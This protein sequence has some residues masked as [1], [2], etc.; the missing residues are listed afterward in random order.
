MWAVL[1]DIH[2][3]LEALEAVLA[4]IAKHPVSRVVC[5]G[6]VV[7]YGPSPIECLERA[8]KWDLVLLGNHD[9]AVL[10]D[11]EGFSANA[12]A[13]ILWTRTVLDWGKRTDLWDYL[14]ERPRSH[15]DGEFLFVH[16]TP[17]DTLNEY[18]FPEDVHN[19][20]KMNQLGSLM[21][22]YCFNGHSH[23]PGVYVEPGGDG[24]GEWK[25]TAPTALRGN[26]YRLD[27]RKTVINVGSVGQPRDG[28]WRASYALV[29]GLDITFR[30]VEYDV[31]ATVKKIHDIPEL[32]DFL[33][34]RLRE[35]R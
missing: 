28:D 33:G 15:V 23:V 3:N 30:R 35:G 13:A 31:D 25:Y 7:G 21:K 19:R 10:L 20:K 14:A 22:R 16:G 26:S 17:R 18:L 27:E 24:S 11:P 4:D 34:D 12:Q 1:S 9:Q 5:L 8:G 32:A 6:D 29:N 2:G